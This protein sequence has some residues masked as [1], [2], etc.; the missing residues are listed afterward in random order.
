M[1]SETPTPTSSI[2]TSTTPTPSMIPATLSTS[3][4]SS[5][6]QP[7]DGGIIKMLLQNTSNTTTTSTCTSPA[8]TTTSTSSKSKWNET[9]IPSPLAAKMPPIDIVE[10]N[11]ACKIF[12]VVVTGASLTV[13]PVRLE[14]P[15]Y[16]RF[17]NGVVSSNPPNMQ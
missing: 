4:K 16:F 1:S 3:S 6:S 11:A 5:P 15:Q 8:T 17:T 10:D 7:K 9:N 2:P 13:R 12:S 14:P